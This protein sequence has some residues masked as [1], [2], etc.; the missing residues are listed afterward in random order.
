M[1]FDWDDIR[2]FLE[3]KRT[4][5]ISQA[6]TRLG[7]SHTTVARRLKQMEERCGCH[8]FEPTDD[9]MSLT[10]AGALILNHAQEMEGAASAISDSLNRYNSRNTGRVRVGAPDGFGNA[11][12]SHILPELIRTDPT[13][14][15]ELV[16]VPATHKLWRRDVDIAISLDRPVT[17]RIVMRKLIDYDLRLYA[18]PDFFADGHLPTQREALQ[19]CP[20]VGYIDELLYTS[21]LDFNR[22]ILPDLQVVYKAATVKAQFDA[23]RN[24]TGLG[25]LPCFM[26]RDSELIP[27]MPEDIAFSRSYWLL[28]PEDYK[29]LARIRRVSDFIFKRTHEM[30]EQFSFAPGRP[31]DPR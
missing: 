27:V 29:S 20:F 19:T 23:V 7:V 5:R 16:P 1:Q 25:V 9:G 2:I 21:E 30:A 28:Y 24:G 14:E 26:A 15:V 18:S 22:F 31:A 10:Q 3:I 17:G 12:L 8:L 4:G 6:A 13:C 11:I